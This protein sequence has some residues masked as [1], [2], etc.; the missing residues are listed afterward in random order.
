MRRA[1]FAPTLTALLL[2]PFASAVYILR[3]TWADDACKTAVSFSEVSPVSGPAGVVDATG[4]T[5]YASP[6]GST[7][8]FRAV[9]TPLGPGLFNGSS[10]MGP[11][12]SGT[13]LNTA[14]SPSGGCNGQGI[15]ESCVAAFA[16]PTSGAVVTKG[17]YGVVEVKSC[18][19]PSS[20][21]ESRTRISASQ[22]PHDAS[23][24]APHAATHPPQN[25]PV[26][27]PQFRRTP[28]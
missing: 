10:Y 22:A 3:E 16:G 12:C 28:A 19:V 7:Y 14:S 18:P 21:V 27:R 1:H 11:G 23:F 26:P 20:A 17:Y 5:T 9:C 25:A 6:G 2:I 24:P 4:C 15:S 13:L 8:S